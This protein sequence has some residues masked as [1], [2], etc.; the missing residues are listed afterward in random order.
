MNI[1]VT[2]SSGLI[3]T[4]VCSHLQG[5]GHRVRR[6]LRRRTNAASNDLFWTP[7]ETLDLGS[8][9]DAVIHLAG[10]TI[11]G[12]WNAS[13]KREVLE[14]RVIGTRS[15]AE[16]VALAWKKHGKPTVLIST[17][18]I[19]YYGNRGDETLTE[20]SVSGEGF[21][22]EVCRQWET[23][24]SVASGAGARVVIFRLGLVLS[25]QGGALAKMLPAFKLGIAG[26]I[27]SGQQF[28]S[29]VSLNDVVRAIE[30]ALA[31]NSLSGP[32]NLV[33]PQPVTNAEFTKTLAT[34]LHRPA[35]F[36][37]PAPI[38]RLAF[39]SESANELILASQRVSSQKL[40]SAGFKFEDRELRQ[41]LEQMLK[42]G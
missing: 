21:L 11:S 42:K 2:G 8:D 17:S 26:K 12:R 34:A 5:I 18:A 14:S 16:S 39:G 6:L 38:A 3:G 10:R 22:A 27:G 9:T 41:C 29:W 13:R 30:C 15:I 24:T 28:W 19:G 33:A 4:A 31:P 35:F 32:V 37:M 36:A 23:A 1:V 25:P 40:E 20:E 7:G